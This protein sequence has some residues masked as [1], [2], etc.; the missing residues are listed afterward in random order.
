MR[1]YSNYNNHV[2]YS[3]TKMLQLATFTSQVQ[4]YIMKNPNFLTEAK[5]N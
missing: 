5:Y 1:M 4:E 2:S 3:V